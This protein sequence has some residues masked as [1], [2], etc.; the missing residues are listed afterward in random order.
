MNDMK[1]RGYDAERFRQLALYIAER[2]ADD[3]R[4]GKTKLAKILFY[5]D[6][7]AFGQLGDSITGATYSKFPNGPFPRML[8]R[9]LSTMEHEGMGQVVHANYFQ[10][11]QHRL[12]PLSLVD[13]SGFSGPEISIVE[14]A[15]EALRDH[16]AADVSRLSHLEPAWQCVDDW[17]DIPYDLAFVSADP[18][19]E[20]AVRTGREIAERL[21]L[22]SGA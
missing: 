22:L 16:N 19:S 11:D 15:I 8:D 14:Q 13:I 5:S 1:M 9:E 2:C 10:R 20:E 7:G 4:F 12:V 6:F 3:P 17:D 18:P 21:G